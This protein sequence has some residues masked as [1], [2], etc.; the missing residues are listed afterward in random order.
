MSEVRML[1]SE[2]GRSIHE[3]RIIEQRLRQ[4]YRGHRARN[5]EYLMQFLFMF[6]LSRRLKLSELPI[7]LWDRYLPDYFDGVIADLFQIPSC[8]IPV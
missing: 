7:K 8:D 6:P 4:Q 5:V 1:E 3:D 2:I